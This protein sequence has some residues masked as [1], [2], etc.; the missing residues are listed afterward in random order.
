MKAVNNQ[1]VLNNSKGR[2]SKKN[3]EVKINELVVEYL[4][5]KEN[6]YGKSIQYYK[7][8][9]SSFRAKFKPLFSLNDGE[10]KL[11][12][13]ET[14]SKDFILKVGDQWDGSLLEMIPGVCYVLDL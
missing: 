13:W 12:L 4:T 14:D 3:N 7:I 2:P 10:L 11:P 8:T 5:T 6:N 1:T 9:D